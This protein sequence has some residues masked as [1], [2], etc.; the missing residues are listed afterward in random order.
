MAKVLEW[1]IAPLGYQHKI[2]REERTDP[3]EMSRIIP[4][5]NRF[6]SMLQ[7][8]HTACRPSLEVRSFSYIAQLRKKSPDFYFFCWSHIIPIPYFKFWESSHASYNPNPGL[9]SFNTDVLHSLEVCRLLAVALNTMS[10]LPQVTTERTKAQGNYVPCLSVQCRG[11][12]DPENVPLS[13]SCLSTQMLQS[14]WH[15]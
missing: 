6:D 10:T 8:H 7:N 1:V 2:Y 5:P 3:N 15:W 4:V 13:S 11:N 14:K 9:T 12:S